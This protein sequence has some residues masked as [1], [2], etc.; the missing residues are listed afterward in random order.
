MSGDNITP[1]RPDLPPPPTERKIS[2]ELCAFIEH[3]LLQAQ[4]SIDLVKTLEEIDNGSGMDNLRRE[5]LSMALYS[6]L[7][8]IDE[9]FDALKNPDAVEDV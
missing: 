4:A 6:A 9:V 5:T 7:L 2:L 3:R 8:R 1:I